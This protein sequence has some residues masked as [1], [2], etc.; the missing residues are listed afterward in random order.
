MSSNYDPLADLHSSNWEVL[1]H[2]IK[3]LER[4]GI[5]PAGDFLEVALKRPEGAI[6]ADLVRELAHLLFRVAETNGWTKDALSFNNLVTSWPEVLG[7][8]HAERKQSL[9]SQATFEYD[10]DEGDS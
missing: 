4:D 6:D 5:G 9:S 10:E 7:V 2:L 3:T 8:A 1:H